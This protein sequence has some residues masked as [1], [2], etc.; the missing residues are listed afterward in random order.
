MEPR[1]IARA[2]ELWHELGSE[3]FIARTRFTDSYRDVVIDKGQR[4]ASEPLLAMTRSSVS[5]IRS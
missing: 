5:C 3:E 2:M 4:I 1:S